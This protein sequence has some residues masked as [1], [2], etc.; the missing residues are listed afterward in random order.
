MV[1][2]VVL[3]MMVVLVVL[4]MMVVLVAL[5]VMVVLVVL[6]ELVVIV[7]LVVHGDCS[8]NSVVVVMVVLVA[9]M[10]F[11]LMWYAFNSLLQCILKK[12][13]SPLK[14]ERY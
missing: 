11:S 6:V 5:A 1:V 14:D 2:L 13:R 9:V 12:V 4:V 3:V 10:H 7:I 8:C